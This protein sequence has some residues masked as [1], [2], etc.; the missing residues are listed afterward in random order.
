MAFEIPRINFPKAGQGKGAPRIL[1]LIGATFVLVLVGYNSCTTYVKPGEAGV[2]QISYG[3]GKGIEPVVYGTGLHYIGVGEKLHLFPTRVQVL[4]LSSTKSESATDIEGHR[5][6]SAINI[7]TSEGYNVRVDV[8]VLYRI[9]D[10]LRVMQTIG[11]GRLFEDSAV[12]PRA[13]QDLRRTLG[14]LDAEDFY[15]GTKRMDK[16]AEARAQ[17][18][19]ELKD[20]GIEILEVFVKRYVYDQRYQTA[21]EGRKVQDQTVFKNEAEA[22]AAIA[23]AAKNKIVAT[24]AAAVQVELA[25]GEAE[26]HKLEAQADLY[27]RTK[28]AEGNLLIKLAEAQGT[29]LE[30]QALRAAG[31]EN[32]VGLRMADALKNTQVIVLPTDGEGGMNPLDL[33]SLLKRFDVKE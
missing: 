16:A 2:K 20:K 32:L 8:T 7:Q 12:I 27:R 21:I 1:W 9:A 5:T 29:E 15:R 11:P 3:M 28:A 4:E 6:T 30:N 23:A 18:S 33:K 14:E 22:K 24:G 26:V 19:A 13:T 25:R 31:A 17:L 10:P